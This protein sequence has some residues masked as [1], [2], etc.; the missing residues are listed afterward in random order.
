MLSDAFK[1]LQNTFECLST[2][3]NTYTHW[4]NAKFMHRCV[5]VSMHYVEYTPQ[6]IW[7][8]LHPIIAQRLCIYA[9][10]QIYSPNDTVSNTPPKDTVSVGVDVLTLRYRRIDSGPCDMIFWSKFWLV[11]RTKTALNTFRCFQISSKYLWM[12]FNITKYL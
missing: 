1:Y 11:T 12:P 2:S 6:S 10:C 3:P 8:K 9:L 7:C 5:H 4:C